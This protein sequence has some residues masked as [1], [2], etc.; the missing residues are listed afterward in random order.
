MAGTA[1]KDP[2]VVKMAEEFIP[3]LVDNDDAAEKAFAVRY[4]IPSTPVIV[5]TDPTGEAIARTEDDQPADT[6]LADMRT[7]L[8]F[9]AEQAREMG[10]GK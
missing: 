1:F 5:Y 2:Q 4:G 8:D 6:V 3:V 7:A 10:G 9:L